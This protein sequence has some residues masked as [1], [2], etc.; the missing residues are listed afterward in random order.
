MQTI[1]HDI[2]DPDDVHGFKH[3]LT[4]CILNPKYK[5]LFSTCEVLKLSA[6]NLIR[7]TLTSNYIH[8][9]TL[10]CRTE[11]SQFNHYT[12]FVVIADC[13]LRRYE[14][15]FYMKN[16]ICQKMLCTY[17]ICKIQRSFTKMVL[18]AARDWV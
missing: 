2:T 10:Y 6:Q 18:F 11:L 1:A 13:V 8:F 9:K 7:K 15:L 12:L 17:T 14:K 5:S 3:I 16:L 4:I